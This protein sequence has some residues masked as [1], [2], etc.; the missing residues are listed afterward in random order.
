M[1]AVDLGLT[2]TL[3]LI[4]LGVYPLLVVCFRHEDF[5]EADDADAFALIRIMAVHHRHFERGI[6]AH[7][8]QVLK[9]LVESSSNCAWTLQVFVFFI[10]IS[11]LSQVL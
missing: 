3:T 6:R 4:V 9:L 8:R 7:V 10:L 11:L 2:F 1:L 5:S